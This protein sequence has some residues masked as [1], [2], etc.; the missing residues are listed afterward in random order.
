MNTLGAFMN[1]TEQKNYLPDSVYTICGEDTQAC[2][3][4]ENK[5][6]S[7]VVNGMVH[8]SQRGKVFCPFGMGDSM[9]QPIF[10][11]QGILNGTK[12][13]ETPNW[14]KT[15]WGHAP[16]M[17]PRSLTKVGLTWRTS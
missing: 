13:Q 4:C 3:V 14:G 12:I 1:F 16:Q 5:L 9:N 15:T 17:D 6:Y 11:D 8:D 2:T 10:G 7:N